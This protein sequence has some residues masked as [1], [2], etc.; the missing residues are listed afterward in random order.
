MILSSVAG[1]Q[2]SSAKENAS[3]VESIDRTLEEIVQL[4]RAHVGN[5]R[6]GLA[7]RRL[8][9]ASREEGAR[10]RELYDTEAKRDLYARQQ[11][12]LLDRRE[13]FGAAPPEGSGMTDSDFEYMLRQMDIQAE[14]A[15]QNLWRTDQRIIDLRQELVRIREDRLAWEEMVEASFVDD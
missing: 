11:Q 5:Q 7:V 3:A 6:A 4:L 2:E 15:K 1:A 10:E 8:E 13:T 9:I 14:T 12:E